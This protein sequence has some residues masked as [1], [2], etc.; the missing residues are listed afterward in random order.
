M[1]EDS[2]DLVP[3]QECAQ[4]GKDADPQLC[5]NESIAS[6]PTWRFPD[7][8]E[9][10]GTQTFENIAEKSGCSIEEVESILFESTE[11]TN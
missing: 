1:F 10:I 7:G 6:Y 9:L 3:Y 5:A 11:S 2:R 4:G 8:S